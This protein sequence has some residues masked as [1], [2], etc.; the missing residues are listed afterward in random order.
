MIIWAGPVET[1][2]PSDATTEEQREEFVS[3][4]NLRSQFLYMKS[5]SQ[6]LGKDVVDA[7]YFDKSGKIYSA[8]EFEAVTEE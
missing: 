1:T 3:S 8:G 7:F 6:S 2:L 4:F 5:F